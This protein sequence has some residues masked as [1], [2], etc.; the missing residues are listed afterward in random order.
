MSLSDIVEGLRKRT[1]TYLGE[2]SPDALCIE[3]ADE[4]ERLRGIIGRALAVI[5]EFGNLNGFRNLSDQEL[6]ALVT[7]VA[8][9]CAEALPFPTMDQQRR[10]NEAREAHGMEPHELQNNH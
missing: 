1:Y 7:S 5:V 4:I 6:G 9:E 10:V 8:K 2:Q 3:A